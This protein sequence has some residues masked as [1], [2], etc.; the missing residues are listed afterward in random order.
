L[1]RCQDR[2][3][4][5]IRKYENAFAAFQMRR[6]GVGRFGAPR[7]DFPSR[8]IDYVGCGLVKPLQE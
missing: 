6:P 8:Q 3:K 4:N 1:L 5:A 7:L 2:E